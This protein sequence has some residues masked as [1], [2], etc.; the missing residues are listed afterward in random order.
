MACDFDRRAVQPDFLRED[1]AFGEGLVPGGCHVENAVLIQ[2]LVGDNSAD[3]FR[4]GKWH[5]L[6]HLESGNLEL[7]FQRAR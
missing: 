5:A 3:Q 6:E 7:L 2:V 4:R 1:V